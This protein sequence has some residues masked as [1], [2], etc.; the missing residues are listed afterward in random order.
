MA[1][2]AELAHLDAVDVMPEAGAS[3]QRC[4]QILAEV[5]T[6]VGGIACSLELASGPAVR[7]IVASACCHNE[8]EDVEHG[9]VEA[10]QIAVDSDTKV[11]EQ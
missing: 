7:E 11:A 6:R 10:V 5:L 1:A 9:V 4:A 8:L 2:P 3:G